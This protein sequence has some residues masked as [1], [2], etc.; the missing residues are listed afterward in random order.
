MRK[1]KKEETRLPWE[2]KIDPQ[3]EIVNTKSINSRLA[4]IQKSENL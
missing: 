1:L 2:H 4:E 3:K